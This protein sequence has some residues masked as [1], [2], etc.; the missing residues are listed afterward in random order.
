ME[1]LYHA[2]HSLERNRDLSSQDW[3]YAMNNSFNVRVGEVSGCHF[4]SG[5][6]GLG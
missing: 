6:V 5:C 2:V 3:V 1:V 4:R